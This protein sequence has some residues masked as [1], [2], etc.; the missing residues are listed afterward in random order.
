MDS[1]S[2][3]ALPI[4]LQQSSLTSP[5]LLSDVI[6]FRRLQIKS[7]T[8]GLDHVNCDHAGNVASPGYQDDNFKSSSL[9]V[10]G[11]LDEF[12]SKMTELITS[13]GR[14]APAT[15]AAKELV[16]ADLNLSI[17]VDQ[18]LKYQ[19]NKAFIQ[20]LSKLSSDLDSQ[21]NKLLLVLADA[22]AELIT[23]PSARQQQQ[24]S[25]PKSKINYSEL[26]TYATKIS[27][28][29]SAPPGFNPPP[30]W[31]TAFESSQAQHNNN[32]TPSTTDAAAQVSPTSAGLSGDAKIQNLQAAAKQAA[33]AAIAEMT[34]NQSHMPVNLP[35]PAEDEM[36][37]G[38][39][40][41][42]NR[43]IGAAGDEGLVKTEIAVVV[44]GQEASSNNNQQQQRR[45]QEVGSDQNQSLTSK[46][47]RARPGSK[48]RR[49]IKNDESNGIESAGEADD[50]EQDDYDDDE[51]DEDGQDDQDED[52]GVEVISNLSSAENK[53]TDEL[54]EPQLPYTAGVE[55]R[56]EHQ[57]TQEQVPA[58]D[59]KQKVNNQS[60]PESKPQS[61]TTFLD[62][63]LFDPDDE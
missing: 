50:D 17:A 32:A 34:G 30:A 25:E 29:T 62:L 52:D 14:Y 11:A 44:P 1:S 19:E 18:L 16:A 58:E 60:P 28:F 59:N 4:V 36:R 53:A 56:E 20:K 49:T 45:Q 22:R 41:Q 10:V 27:K 6:S 9:A 46:R 35:W 47:R 24:S 21:I 7:S 26:L 57:H 37:R 33:A 40:A 23:I 12:E 39:L 51:D 55:T 63:D 31:I 38:V 48:R 3:P 8:A 15:T 43:L 54:A 61:A 2:I 13:V 5:P 42:Y